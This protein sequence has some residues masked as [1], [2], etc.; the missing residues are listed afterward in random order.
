MLAVRQLGVR[1]HLFRRLDDAAGHAKSLEVRHQLVRREPPIGGHIGRIVGHRFGPRGIKG[2]RVQ[3]RLDV[4]VDLLLFVQSLPA[5][6]HALQVAPFRAAQGRLEALPM[7]LRAAGEYHVAAVAADVAAMRRGLWVAVS[8][9][10]LLVP[11]GRPIENRR[12]QSMDRPLHLTEVD[13]LPDARPTAVVQRGDERRG[14]DVRH[15]EVGVRHPCADRRLIGPTGQ[16]I[17]A[18]GRLEHVTVAHVAA[19]RAILSVKRH[20]D[21]HDVLAYSSQRFIVQSKA[22]HGPRR[23]R[24][25][26]HVAPRHQPLHHL[27]S[28]RVLQV[29]GHAELGAVEVRVI[30][31]AIDVRDVIDKWSNAAQR[32]GVGGGF[33]TDYFGAMV[34]EILAHQRPDT[35]PG[36]VRNAKTFKRLLSDFFDGHQSTIFIFRRRRS[37]GSRPSSPP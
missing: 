22:G 9:A 37:A 1:A 34:R 17:D 21:H 6:P 32:L 19:P 5:P 36:Q 4:A 12:A 20:R 16:V 24:L 18:R 8:H 7:L 33:D 30:A 29:H 23:K 3:P 15:Q 27:R 2:H 10:R 11:V 26:D 13:V 35:D 28:P 31:R 14:G 25:G